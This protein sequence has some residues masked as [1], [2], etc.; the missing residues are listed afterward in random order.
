MDGLPPWC[1]QQQQQLQQQLQQQRQQ[2]Q[3]LHNN[4]H[5]NS[6]ATLLEQ[7]NVL[8][9]VVRCL[10]LS[11]AYALA[12]VGR[13]YLPKRAWENAVAVAGPDLRLLAL[14]AA[15]RSG[16]QLQEVDVV[17]G[18][19]GWRLTRSCPAGTMALA[20]GQ[21]EVFLMAEP[22]QLWH[23]CLEGEP[24]ALPAGPER[25]GARA[26]VVGPGELVV[27]GGCGPGGGVEASCWFFQL[28][29]SSW[30]ELP[31]MSAA[32]FHHGCVF[33]RSEQRLVVVGGRGVDHEE[34]AACES[35]DLRAQ[36]WSAL[37][38]MTSPRS[39]SAVAAVEGSVYALGGFGGRLSSEVL[40]WGAGN[41]NN[42][43]NN[44]DNN[45]NYNNKWMPLAAVPFGDQWGHLAAVVSP[46]IFVHCRGDAGQAAEYSPARNTWSSILPA[47]AQKLDDL[48]TVQLGQA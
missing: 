7:G 32:R 2:L 29:K 17:R 12:C 34:L 10:R 8:E 20:A 9:G 11:Q 45:N 1:V 33:L 24:E 46:L 3:Q 21:N 16:G 38:A 30:S 44:N 26:C 43:N 15:G 5:N 4:H 47:C 25:Y 41:N 42:D 28:A 18:T 48:A 22:R 36:S 35:F 37:P 31:P 39:D 23:W 19:A 13:S 14:T 40:H 6:L 27:T